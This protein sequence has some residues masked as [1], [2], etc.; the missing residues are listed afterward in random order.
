MLAGIAFHLQVV[1]WALLALGTVAGLLVVP[2]L[3][4]NGRWRDPLPARG[5]SVGGPRPALALGVLLLFF[6]LP[7]FI[8]QGTLGDL[9]QSTIEA[10]LQPGTDTWHRLQLTDSLVK[11]GLCT[12]MFVVLHATRVA[13]RPPRRTFGPGLVAGVLG[14]L[15][16]VPCVTLQLKMGVVVWDWIEPAAAP[17]EHPVLEALT[18][19]TWGRWGIVQLVVGAVVVAPLAEELLFRGVLLGSLW[20]YLRL[21]WTAIVLS[22]VAFGW[23]H[24]SQPQAILPMITM[25]VILGYLRLRTGLLWPCVLVH[26]LFNARTIT[27]NLLAPEL[28]NAT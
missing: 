5:I 9:S 3:L 27:F 24:A 26:A 14:T 25:G 7:L 28:V 2:R 19:S 1:D 20:Q 8:I 18:A 21:P 11:V 13:H 22:S 6:T 12:I 16:L 15:I 10:S 23:V 4:A 17:P